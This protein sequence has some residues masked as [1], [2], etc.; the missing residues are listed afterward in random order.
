MQPAADAWFPRKEESRANVRPAPLFT[1]HNPHASHAK[2]RCSVLLPE[3]LAAITFDR[4]LAPSAPIFGLCRHGL[5]QRAIRT[6]S[7]SV[8]RIPES[9]APSAGFRP[10]PA[11]FVWQMLYF[12][13]RYDSMRAVGLQAFFRQKFCIARMS[14]RPAQR[15]PPSQHQQSD[16]MH[17]QRNKIRGNQLVA[18]HKARVFRTVQLP[19][20]RCNRSHARHI[21]QYEHEERISR[22]RRKQL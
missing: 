7:P 3:R 13:R 19:P 10:S 22:Q 14:A 1:M 8:Y 4:R 11:S 6:Q 5:L 12:I 2:T 20:H 17:E 9:F 16:P 21:Q 18:D 15:N